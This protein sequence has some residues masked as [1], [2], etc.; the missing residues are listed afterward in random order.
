MVAE[1]VVA[2]S[3]IGVDEGND[4]A[5]VLESETAVVLVVLDDEVLMAAELMIPFP[6]TA[7]EE[8]DDDVETIGRLVVLSNA[9]SI[10]AELELAL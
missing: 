1:L 5:E 10:V 4:D 6:D 9:G 2:I 3:D 7:V 8:D